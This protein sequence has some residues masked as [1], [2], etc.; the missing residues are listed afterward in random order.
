MNDDSTVRLRPIG[1]VTGGRTEVIDDDWGQVAAV[2]R[3]DPAQYGAEALL[4][5]DAFTH[6]EVVFHFH[7]VAE[8]KI[9]TTA[10]RP[11]GNPEWPEVGIFA[12]RGKNRPNR[13]GVSRCRLV[14]VDGL[15]VHVLGLDAVDGTPVLDL[16]PW[17]AEFGPL[18]DTGQPQWATELMRAYY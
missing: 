5:L 11:R 14:A 4:G 13:L 12:Q 16:K 18:G 10:R 3:L 2:I 6:L 7:K 9:E 15:D 8:E 1:L 17:M